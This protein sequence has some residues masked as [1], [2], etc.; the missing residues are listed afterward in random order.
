MLILRRAQV[1]ALENAKKAGFFA[2]V[3]RYLVAGPYPLL[4]EP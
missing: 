2:R 3:S 4:V 1:E